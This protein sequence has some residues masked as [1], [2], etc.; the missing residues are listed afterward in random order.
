MRG[1]HTTL[2]TVSSTVSNAVIGQT[3]TMMAQI[4]ITVS[5]EKTCNTTDGGDCGDDYDDADENQCNLYK[6]CYCVYMYY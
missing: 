5:Y 3:M 1:A 4:Q 6:W 2:S